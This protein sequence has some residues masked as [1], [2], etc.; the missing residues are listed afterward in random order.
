M[1]EDEDEDDL[2]P[3]WC[4]DRNALE[5]MLANL[6]GK[7][8]PKGGLATWTSDR[9]PRLE[10]VGD[11]SMSWTCQFASDKLR[12]DLVEQVGLAFVDRSGNRRPPD[13]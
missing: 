5:F 11:W 4:A 12:L 6:A 10:G 8:I 3:R 13:S 1:C 9:L 2:G 7:S